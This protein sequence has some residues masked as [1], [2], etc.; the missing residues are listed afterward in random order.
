MAKAIRLAPL[1]KQKEDICYMLR[2][3]CDPSSV[4]AA[5]WGN[6]VRFGDYVP[7]TNRQQVANYSAPKQSRRLSGSDHNLVLL[8]W[9]LEPPPHQLILIGSSSAIAGTYV[10]CRTSQHVPM[11][12]RKSYN[13]HGWGS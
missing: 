6:H 9:T 7:I 12:T 11:T 4:A 10:T 3:R 5:P 8:G 1:E 2:R 13:P